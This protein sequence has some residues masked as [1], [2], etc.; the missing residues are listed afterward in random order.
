MIL[1]KLIR[2]PST[3]INLETFSNLLKIIV[4]EFDQYQVDYKSPYNF[5]ESVPNPNY[6]S[7][8]IPPDEECIYEYREADF[9]FDMQLKKVTH[10]N[11]NIKSFFYQDNIYI[12]PCAYYYSQFNASN[13]ESLVKAFLM[14]DTFT[15]G[16]SLMYGKQTYKQWI[17]AH[18]DQK[19]AQHNYKIDQEDLAKIGIEV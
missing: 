4:K 12:A 1:E 8:S 5:L 18:P 9:G 15:L 2:I 10:I 16:N 14:S 7:N 6:N 13:L 17:D 11:F 3:K 19:W